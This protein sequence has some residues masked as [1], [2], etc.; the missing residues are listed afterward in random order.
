[1]IMVEI[2]SVRTIDELRACEELQFRVWHMPDYREVVPL[3]LLVAA[4]KSG[5]LLLAAVDGARV[6]GFVFGFA[7]LS[8][9]G[10]LY[11][12]SHMMA[13]APEVQDQGVGWQL[14]CAQ[15]EAILAQGLD[16][17]CWTYDPL[18]ARNAHLNIAKLGAVCCT[19]LRDLYGPMTDGLNAGLPSD[20]FQVDWWIASEWVR[21]R[22]AGR[23]KPALLEPGAW[24]LAGEERAGGLRAPGRP[25]LGAGEP[26]VAVEIP[27]DYQAVKAADAELALAWRLAARQALEDCFSGGY[28]VV[29]MARSGN[30]TGAR[31]YYILQHGKEASWSGSSA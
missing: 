16:R 27:A 17:I 24:V 3:H 9:E 30:V 20:R 12:Y 8:R 23:E 1:M 31:A 4:Q 25:N 28:R 10:R 5:G 21:E 19:Y 11:H 29:G 13:V 18:E 2:R 15:R 22:L 26:C 6:L 14:K 7:G